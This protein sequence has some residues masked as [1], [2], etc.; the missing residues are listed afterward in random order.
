MN[1]HKNMI[2]RLI[3]IGAAVLLALLLA[4]PAMADAKTSLPPASFADLVEQVSPAVVNIRIVKTVKGNPMMPFFRGQP[5][6]Q[7]QR[8]PF[9][10]DLFEKFF[11]GPGSKGAPKEFQT[12][13]PGLGRDHRRRGLPDH[14]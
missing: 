13:L 7:G 11:G 10:D 1:K 9:P 2:T 4:L 3:S 8:S 6:R 14:Q 12:A 5:G